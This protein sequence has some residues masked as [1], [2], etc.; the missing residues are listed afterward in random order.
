MAG[1]KNITVI[2]AKKRVGNTVT[3]EDKPK[4]KVAAYCRVSTDSEEQAT[5]YD[6]QVE[7]YTEF[8]RKNPEWEFAGIYAD[9]GINGTNTKARRVQSND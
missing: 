5:S 2:P 3:T 9:D 7:H 1:A 4:L 6:A 8:I